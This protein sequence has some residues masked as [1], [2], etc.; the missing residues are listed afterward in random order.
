MAAKCSTIISMLPNDNAV[1]AV[2]NAI[3]ANKGVCKT[4]IGCS[5][6]SPTTSR[7]LAAEF[8]TVGI[9]FIASPVFARPDGLAKRQAVWMVAGE[10]EGRDLAAKLLESSGR[11]RIPC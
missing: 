9:Q 3:L 6:V 5:T 10:K 1:N 7:R 11:V 8:K 2:S 4:H